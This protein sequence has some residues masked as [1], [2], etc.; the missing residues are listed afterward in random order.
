M[1]L[2]AKPSAPYDSTP[3]WATNANYAAGE[4]AGNPTKIEPPSAQE[5][6]GW[7]P[8][9]RPPAQYQNFWQHSSGLWLA[10]AEGAIDNLADRLGGADGT[11]EWTY[12]D[13]LRSRAVMI[14]PRA[15]K[16]ESGW[17]YNLIDR[18]KC[19]ENSHDLFI[20][21]T[22]YLTSGV[23]LRRVRALVKP[24][25]AR[26]SG[27]RME[28]Q[29]HRVA[30]SF[31]TPADPTETQLGATDE[32]NGSTAHQLLDSGDITDETIDRTET[33]VV[34]WLRA[35]NTSGT[36]GQED[37][38]YGLQVAFDDPGPRND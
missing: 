20:D 21:I 37:E 16:G 35:G 11:G 3:A 17:S 10:W 26:G 1:A 12:E 38:F 25:A 19:F 14:G 29:V 2:P 23:N 8:G 18:A 30:A 24:G 4:E 34:A 32:D 6:D 9:E 7:R 36:G 22:D 15:G 28:L 13:G 31:T 27:N 33:I 5:Q